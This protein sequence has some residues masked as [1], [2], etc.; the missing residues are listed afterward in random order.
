MT[1]R[2]LLDISIMVC[3][4]VTAILLVQRYLPTSFL[5]GMDANHNG[6]LSREEWLA[7][8]RRHPRIYGGFD[9]R[10]YIPGGDYNREFDRVD[11]DRNG[12]MSRCEYKQLHWNMR[13]CESDLKPRGVRAWLEC[14]SD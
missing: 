12:Q 8:H 13:W 7:Y 1:P 4:V 10:G 5:P 11:C 9:S 3:L 6:R 2:R 14:M